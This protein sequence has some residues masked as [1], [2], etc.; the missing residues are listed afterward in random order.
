M[1]TLTQKDISLYIHFPWCIRKCPYCD[2]NSHTQ[3]HEITEAAYIQKLINELDSKAFLLTN[4]KIRSIFIGGGTP[5]I[6]S[7]DGI[8]RLLNSIMSNYHC[9]DSVEITMEAN[10]GTTEVQYLAEY[11][12]AGVNRLSLGAQSF[13][14]EQLTKIGR[15]HTAKETFTAFEQA[16]HIGYNNINIDIMFGL[17]AQSPDSAI[18]DLNQA[19]DLAPEHISWYQLTIEPHTAFAFRPPRLPIDEDI[20]RMQQ[21]GQALLQDHHYA[22]YEVSA[23]AQ[24]NKQCQHN[25][26]YWQ[27]GDYVGIGAGA[28]S[29]LT[30]NTGAYREW[31]IKHPKHYMKSENPQAGKKHIQPSDI[32]FEYFLNRMRLQTPISEMELCQHTGK[33]FNDIENTLNKLEKLNLL[34]W[35]KHLTLTSKGHLF[36]N[37]VLEYFI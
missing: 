4:K 16:R 28:H 35:K 9:T 14:D 20:F 24:P 15:I 7:G 11:H 30:G 10:P 21:Q 1:N 5:S 33:Q 36:L 2:F 22:Q 23:Y 3:T 18:S 12:A 37:D 13:N 17:P 29:K 34:T 6:I 26:N 19:I 25:L 8:R 31:N 32:V 27:F